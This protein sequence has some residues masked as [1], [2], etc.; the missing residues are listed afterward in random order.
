MANFL[1]IK[2]PSGNTEFTARFEIVL[3]VTPRHA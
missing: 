3:G 2:A 1:P